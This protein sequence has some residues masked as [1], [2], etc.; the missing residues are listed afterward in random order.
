MFSVIVGIAKSGSLTSR[1]QLYLNLSKKH[2]S[3]MTFV[4]NS[5][6]FKIEKI[7][8]FNL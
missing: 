1:R 2:V 7:N 3:N 6:K 4:F 8:I 5:L